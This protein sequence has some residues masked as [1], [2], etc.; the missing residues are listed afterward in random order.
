MSLQLILAEPQVQHLAAS[1]A[2]LVRPGDT[3]ALWGDLGAG[4]TTL[5]RALIRTLMGD[6]DHDV[7][8]P[9]F[10]LRQDYMSPAGPIAHFD[11]YRIVQPH[12]VDELG[13]DD[14]A[15]SAIVIVE[16]PGRAHAHLPVD[17]LDLVIS[18][19]GSKSV[20]AVEICGHG[21]MTPMLSAISQDA[22]NW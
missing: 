15:A 5:A 16:W 22:A 2:R 21:L 9:T 18:E 13:F 4:K 7:P 6:P 1:L 10:A 3:L 8:S 20:R 14:A 17:R 11:F 12:D 19:T